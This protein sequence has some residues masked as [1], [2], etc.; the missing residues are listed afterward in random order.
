MTIQGL[1]VALLA[2]GKCLGEPVV[3]PW[4]ANRDLSTD[5]QLR[6]D[7]YRLA[8]GSA[9][10]NGLDLLE[11]VLVAS[12]DGRLHALNRTSGDFIWSMKTASGTEP[13]TLGPLVRTKHPEIDPDLT[14]DDSVHREVYLVEPQSGDIYI[15]STPDGPLQRLPFSMPQLVDMSPFSFPSDDDRRMFIGRKE[16]SLLLVELETGRVRTMNHECPWDPF[17]DLAEPAEF[18]LDL[19]DLEGAEPPKRASRPTEVFIGRT[20]ELHPPLTA[21]HHSR[22]ADY[23]ISI[24]TRPS[25]SSAIRPPVQNLSFSV[26][27]PNNQDL[28]IQSVYRRTADNAY[29][30]PLPNGEI[31]SFTSDVV[32]GADSDVARNTHFEWGR[33]FSTPVVAV[34]DILRSPQRSQPFVLLQPRLHLEDILPSAELRKAAAR[35]SMPF[36]AAFVGIVEETGSLYAMGP[37]TFPL[38][39][40]GDAGVGRFLDAAPRD[41]HFDDE[42]GR[43]GDLPGDL[44]SVTRRAKERRLQK[45]CREGSNDL[46]CLTGVRRLEAGT[47]SRF[48]RLLDAAPVVPSPLPERNI[49]VHAATSQENSTMSAQIILDSERVSSLSASTSALSAFAVCALAL[50]IAFVWMGLKRKS[51]KPS[52]PI[53]TTAVEPETK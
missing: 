5:V 41:T 47:Q 36:D 17:Q 7:S 13:A 50:L 1:L 53:S 3:S 38:V 49:S 28:G 31:V 51:G 20:G 23:H 19:D 24:H 8:Q 43:D 6:H 9:A 26:Y 33:A 4:T 10:T 35:Q 44:D 16:T 39:I 29:I 2:A 15:M 18:G 32:Q 48:S 14:D 27:G 22:S 25:R 45:M 11:I 21:Q 42:F 52:N 46:R 12:V 40:F 34:F 30:Q 37:D